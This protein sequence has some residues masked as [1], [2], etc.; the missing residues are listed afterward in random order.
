MVVDEVVWL[1]PTW[2]VV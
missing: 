2:N 1:K